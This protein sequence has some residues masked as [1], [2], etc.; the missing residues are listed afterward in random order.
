M[1]GPPSNA[2]YENMP[3][4]EFIKQPNVIPLYAKDGSVLDKVLKDIP[5]IRLGKI[6][7]GDYAVFYMDSRNFFDLFQVI[8]T[9]HAEMIPEAMGLMGRA[10]LDASNITQVQQHPYLDLRGRGTLIGIIDTG[11]DY[12]K[13]AFQ[14]EDSTSKIKYIWDQTIDG[15]HPKGFAFGSEYTNEQ[16]NQALKSDTPYNVV[17]SVDTVGHGTFLAS[18]AA[19]GQDSDYLGAAPEAELLV[20]KL[21]RLHPFFYDNFVIPE[22]QENAFSAAD[23]MLAIQ[24]MVDKAQELEMPLSICIGLG[25]NMS[26][27]D[28][29]SILGQ[30]ISAISQSTGVCICAAAGN[31]SNAGHHASGTIHSETTPYDIQ[32]RVPENANGFPVYIFVNATDR[33]SV[34]VKSPTGETIPRAVPKSGSLIETK[35]I[36]EKS[37]VRSIYYFPLAETG[38]E[39]IVVSIQNPTPGIWTITLYQ[40]TGINGRFDAWLH[41]TGLITPGIEFVVP[42]PNT[43]VVVPATSIGCITVGAYNDKDNSLY[44]NS[45]WG[46]SRDAQQKPDL[47]APGVDVVGINPMGSGTMTGTSVAAAIT[48]GACALMMQWGIVE[49]NDVSLDTYRIKAN[50]IRGCNRDLDIQYPSPLWGYGKLDLLNTFKGLR[51]V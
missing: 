5:Y 30:Y 26:G 36:F 8:G 35:L 6:V 29:Y 49:K 27:H 19:S 31:E 28:G 16:I 9:T 45:S 15:T 21:R 2:H 22:N 14:F 48:A 33:M 43:T 4:E 44:I 20:V 23:V 13:K 10:S 40:D 24:Y 38:V 42:D 3:L 46:P 41:V 18:V 39:I 37:I 11:I 47:V 1:P 25:S 12:T 51:S 50:L 17:P 7:H 32:I 34:S